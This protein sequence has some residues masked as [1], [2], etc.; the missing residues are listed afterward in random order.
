MVSCGIYQYIFMDTPFLIRVCQALQRQRVRYAIV[1]GHAVALHGA[2]RGTIDVDIAVNWTL[3]A[4]QR[5][6]TALSDIGLVSRL[7]IT[8]D[9]I[10][11]FRDEYVR[12]RNLVAWNFYNPRNASEQVDVIVTYDLKG[13]KL[14]TLTVGDAQIAILNR[15][16]LINMKRASGRA[17]DL[18]DIKALEKLS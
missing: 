12:N 7:P 4:V 6:E 16:D 18:E 11:S 5:A 1:G 13:R 3:Q 14:K 10:Y 8:A 9:D 17:Q 2:I 15:Q